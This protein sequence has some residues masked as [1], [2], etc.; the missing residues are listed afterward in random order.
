[1][2][3]EKSPA[4]GPPGPPRATSPRQSSISSGRTPAGSGKSSRST[5]RSRSGREEGQ[6]LL[7]VCLALL[8][9]DESGSERPP[10]LGFRRHEEGEAE[11]FLE[12]PARAGVFRH[13]PPPDR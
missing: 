6:I 10:Q 9:G 8:P 5:R 4:G 1:M 3:R 7:V 13:P 11:L 12:R 2:G